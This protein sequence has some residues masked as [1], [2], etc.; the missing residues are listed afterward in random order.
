MSLSFEMKETNLT[1]NYDR[2]LLKGVRFATLRLFS[3]GEEVDLWEHFSYDES[4]SIYD[5]IALDIDER[6]DPMLRFTIAGE[7]RY[8]NDYGP[9]PDAIAN[10]DV[11]FGAGSNA[12]L[13]R[14]IGDKIPLLI[15]KRPGSTDF[16]GIDSLEYMFE[17]QWADPPEV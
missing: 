10:S 2:P 1:V 17:P 9:I 12:R 14:L 5:W 11:Q 6:Y 4:T 13:V 7:L 16:E 15:S 3:N 8:G